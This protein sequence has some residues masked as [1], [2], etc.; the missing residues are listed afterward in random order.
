V[1]GYAALIAQATDQ[2]DPATIA[3]VEELM[4]E[5]AGGVLDHLSAARF[6]A[7]T[8][9]SYLDARAWQRLGQINGVTLADYCTVL[10]LT[11]PSWVS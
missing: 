9:E 3:L 5:E 2:R 10:G 11:V 6:T 4:R 1:K 8:R 7:L